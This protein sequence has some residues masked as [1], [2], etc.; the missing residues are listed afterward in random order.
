MTLNLKNE[1]NIEV[2]F[3]D[4]RH[5]SSPCD[6]ATFLK[7]WEASAEKSIFPYQKFGSIE[8]LEQTIEF[9]TIEDFYSELKQV[10]S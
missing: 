6:L 10:I 7:T 3:K 9:P 1:E 5:Y 8:E 2:V 4:V